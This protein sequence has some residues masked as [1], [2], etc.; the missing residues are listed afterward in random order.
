MDMVQFHIVNSEIAQ[1]WIAITAHM[2]KW[3]LGA[4]ATVI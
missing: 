2:Q 3:L 1:N 4:A